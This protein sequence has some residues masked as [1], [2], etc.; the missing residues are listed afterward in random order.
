MGHSTE[1]I[2]SRS[3]PW[4]RVI[5]V[6]GKCSKKLDGG[7]GS[8]GRDSLRS[9]LRAELKEQGYGRSV[10]IIETRC[11]GVCPKKSV[12]AIDAGNPGRVYMVPKGTP[13]ESILS[14]FENSYP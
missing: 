2:K 3:T 8:S 7:F 4:E 11:M 12:T 5:L 6:C 10:R 14:E 1:S 13:G 9:A